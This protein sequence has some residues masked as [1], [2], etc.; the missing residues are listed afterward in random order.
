MLIAEKRARV[1]MII[2]IGVDVRQSGPID[3]FC[4]SKTGLLEGARKHSTSERI[5]AKKLVP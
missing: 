5:S 4:V 1:C 3:F 2:G